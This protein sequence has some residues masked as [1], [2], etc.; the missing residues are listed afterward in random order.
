MGLLK[1]FGSIGSGKRD[2]FTGPLL[3]GSAVTEDKAGGLEAP[4]CVRDGPKAGGGKLGGGRD[5]TSVIEGGGTFKGGRPGG[6]AGGA[7]RLGGCSAA[8]GTGAVPGGGTFMGGR[9]M[10]AIAGVMLGGVANKL[11]V[12]S[13]I[14]VLG[15]FVEVLV[16]LDLFPVPSGGTALK[17][18]SGGGVAEGPAARGILGGGIECE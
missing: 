1:A 17:L 12:L 6:R 9:V 13:L 2:V 3:G 4:C 10:G 7:P 8:G 18:M 16:M 11:R 15:K 14:L 5:S